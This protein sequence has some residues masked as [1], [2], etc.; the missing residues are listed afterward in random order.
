MKELAQ[1]LITNKIYHP[2]DFMHHA[3][4]EGHN[5]GTKIYLALAI[6]DWDKKI[7]NAVDL[8][9]N[10]TPDTSYQQRIESYT[11][12]DNLDLW[13]GDATY[14]EFMELF[15]HHGI[16]KEKIQG[17]FKTLCG[18]NGKKNTIYFWGKADAGKTTL[19]KL[20]DAFYLHGS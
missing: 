12:P 1:Y 2:E 3:T 11:Q 7:Q 15:Q 13:K 17:F 20:F 10:F 14:T 5:R 6:K 8:A 4:Q 9:R 18:H 19:I 16:P